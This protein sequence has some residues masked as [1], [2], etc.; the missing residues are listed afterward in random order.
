MRITW[1][2]EADVVVLSLW[3]EHVCAGTFR[4]AI[5]DV[6]GFVDA[7][8]DGLRDAP[9]VRIDLATHS[10]AQS[11]SSGRAP[12]FRRGINASG[13][14]PRQRRS[15]VDEEVHEVPPSRNE[16]AG[17]LDWV[18]DATTTKSPAG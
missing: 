14:P 3:R 2:P 1:H 6:S 8:V 10:S 12:R 15:S 13:L 4:L 18:F 17:L 5:D 16:S 9:G 7:L 11:S